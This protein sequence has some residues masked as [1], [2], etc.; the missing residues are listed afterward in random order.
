M[1]PR[2][3]RTASPRKSAITYDEDIEP[4]QLLPLYLDTR[5]KLFEIHRPRQDRGRDKTPK[6]RP[7]ASTASAE[8]A[9]LLAKIDRIEKDV[10]FDKFVAEQQ[11]RTKNIVMEKEYAAAKKKSEKKE[12][13]PPVDDTPTDSEG[14]DDVNREA[15]RIAAEI[16]AENSDDD[17][18]Q[19]LAD[20]F[21]SLPVNEV[22]PL[23]GKSS[24][25]M[26]GADG[27]KVTIRD[28][29]KWVGVN[30]MRTLE[31]ACRS[32][33]VTPHPRVCLLSCDNETSIGILP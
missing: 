30:P 10:L 20:L 7:D 8:E 12:Q 28:F 32:R 14:P 6:A 24:T 1:N 21:S 3:P 29:G 19:A 15:E 25:V 13:E 4:D 27:S 2:S 33:F 23:T 26:N 16:L 18:D 22:D 31:E 11:W 5:A 17:D 9:L